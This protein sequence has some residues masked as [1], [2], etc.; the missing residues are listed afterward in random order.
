MKVCKPLCAKGY[1]LHK[2]G[3]I[4]SLLYAIHLIR[5]QKQ[6]SGWYLHPDKKQGIDFSS[7]LF[8]ASFFYGFDDRIQKLQLLA[9]GAVQRFD[10]LGYCGC[11]DI[12]YPLGQ[13]FLAFCGFGVI[14][15]QIDRR[16]ASDNGHLL[17]LK[18]SNVSDTVMSNHVILG[19]NENLFVN[20]LHLV[21]NDLL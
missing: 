19:Q 12:G 5:E 17:G 18:P 16:H 14:H 10:S 8:P 4:V 2:S 7:S 3:M 6:N 15:D 1:L 9:C 21:G 13:F 11:V 20:Y